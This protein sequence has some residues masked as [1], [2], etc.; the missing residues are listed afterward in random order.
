M[1]LEKRVQGR[2]D[3][4]HV[5]HVQARSSAARMTRQGL[6]DGAGTRVGRGGADHD[7]A[8]A[9]EFESNGSAYAS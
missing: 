2:V 1:L 7:Q 5:I 6:I 3:A 4:G 9:C 8:T